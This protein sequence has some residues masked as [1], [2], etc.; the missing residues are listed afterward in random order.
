MGA[1]LKIM[2]GVESGSHV[3]SPHVATHACAA[4]VLRPLDAPG[5]TVAVVDGERGP[6]GGGGVVA[7]GVLPGA[8]RLLVRG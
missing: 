7:V 8:A 1:A 5:G 3:T 4:L 6:G 2:V